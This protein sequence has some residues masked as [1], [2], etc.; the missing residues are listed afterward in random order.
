MAR[1]EGL[2]PPTSGSGG[3][4]SIQ[5]SYR[6]AKKPYFCTTILGIVAGT[7]KGLGGLRS[8]V[9]G[10]RSQASGIRCQEFCR[11]DRSEVARSWVW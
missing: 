5:L 1:L 4:R 6:R 3:Q 2:E 7:V 10:V 9:P 8:R 11:D